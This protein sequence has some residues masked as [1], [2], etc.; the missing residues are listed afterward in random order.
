M[1]T[2][3]QVGNIGFFECNRM[4]FSLCNAPATFQRLMERAM[5]DIKSAGLPNLP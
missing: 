3:F 4:P 2:A 1:K 5:G